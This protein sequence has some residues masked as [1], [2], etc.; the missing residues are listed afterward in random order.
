MGHGFD[1][2]TGNFSLPARGVL[3]ERGEIIHSVNVFINTKIE[4]ILK[5]I[6]GISDV[7]GYPSWT[8]VISPTIKVRG[9]FL[10]HIR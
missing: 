1:I 6:E 5:N 2:A 4:S 8:D 9:L 10:S 3:V 7:L